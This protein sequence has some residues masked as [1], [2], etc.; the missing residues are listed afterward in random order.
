MPVRFSVALP[1]LVSVTLCAELAVPTVCDENV[2][3]VGAR[4]TAGA[5]AAAPVP[6]R[7]AV[8]GLPLA[9]LAI[10]TE[11]VR[12]PLAVGLKVTLI[13]QFALAAMLAP[14]VLVWL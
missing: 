3:R 8:C 2:R 4:V 9:L 5:V 14:Q 7:F 12:V 1:L 6:D 10:E 13:V 11:A